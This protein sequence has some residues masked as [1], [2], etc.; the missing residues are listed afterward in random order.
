MGGCNVETKQTKLAM[1]PV[2]DVFARAVTRERLLCF[3]MRNYRANI[4]LSN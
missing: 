1:C 2:E 3:R 4:L